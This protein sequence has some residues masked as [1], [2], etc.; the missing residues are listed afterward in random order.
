MWA[1][2]DTGAAPAGAGADAAVPRR[3]RHGPRRGPGARAR[4]PGAVRPLRGRGLRPTRRQA[5][6]LRRRRAGVPARCV[7]TRWS[8]ARP[9]S[10]SRE[11]EA[12]CTNLC[13]GAD[14]GCGGT[15]AGAGA[16]WL[17]VTEMMLFLPDQH[18]SGPRPRPICDDECPVCQIILACVTLHYSDSS[19]CS[20]LKPGQRDRGPRDFESLETEFTKRRALLRQRF[21]LLF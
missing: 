20:R 5:G 16:R 10:R 1:H 3:R 12:Q 8:L 18:R 11:C 4:L 19:H 14:D 6:L 9:V 13:G 17:V 7:R 15:W 2:L 21:L